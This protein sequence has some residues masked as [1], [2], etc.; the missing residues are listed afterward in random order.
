MKL[1]LSD[2]DVPE[3]KNSVNEDED[4]LET[5]TNNWI[6]IRYFYLLD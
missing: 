1:H 4:N 5:R 6:P 3:I 2:N